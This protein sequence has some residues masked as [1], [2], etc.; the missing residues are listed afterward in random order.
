M[1]LAYVCSPLKAYYDVDKNVELTEEENIMLAEQYCI[2]VMNRGYIP[3][4]PHVYFTQFLDDRV[5]AQRAQG[6]K[7]GL[8]A[9]KYCLKMFVF[10]SYISAGMKA[11]IEYA[12][13]NYIEIEYIR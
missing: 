4:A 2:I 12:K 9:I 3:F 6:L 10:G 13:M 1:P 8:D 7:M 5:E 11:E